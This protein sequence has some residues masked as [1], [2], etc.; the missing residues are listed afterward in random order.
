MV[1]NNPQ[2]HEKALQEVVENSHF[3]CLDLE[4]LLLEKTV[5]GIPPLPLC[6]K[7]EVV[8]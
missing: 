4:P 2:S 1:L 7:V 8:I 5:S 6:C 3:Q